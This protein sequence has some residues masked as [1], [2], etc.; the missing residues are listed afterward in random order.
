M[1]AMAMGGRGSGRKSKAADARLMAELRR[2]KASEPPAAVV[3]SWKSTVKKAVAAKK[4]K[5]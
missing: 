2:A 5:P 1:T 4:R 3:K